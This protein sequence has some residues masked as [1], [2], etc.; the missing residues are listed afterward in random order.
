MAPTTHKL[1]WDPVKNAVNLRK[2]KIDFKSA[3]RFNWPYAHIET[4][5]REDYGELRERATGFIGDVL[6]VLIFT[7][8]DDV[9]WIISLRTA[10]KGERKDYVKATSHQRDR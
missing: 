2:H 10:N 3:K 5:G 4:D 1:D 8:R 9:T 6:H 7:E